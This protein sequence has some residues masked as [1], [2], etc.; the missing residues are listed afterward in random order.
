MID[1]VG[2]DSNKEQL[3]KYKDAFAVYAQRRVFECP[4]QFGAEHNPYDTEL[5]IKL[6]ER[7]E[8]KLDELKKFQSRL[9]VILKVH[10]YVIRLFSVEKGCFQLLFLLPKH[11]QALTFPLSLEQENDLVRLH[12]RHLSCGS[13]LFS[14]PSPKVIIGTPLV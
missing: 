5:H 2:T 6:D 12:V 10:V 11:I 14:D 9:C 4:C 1:L 7:Y 13:Y 8:C 3:S